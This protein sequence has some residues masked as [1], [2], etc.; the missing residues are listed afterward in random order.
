MIFIVFCFIFKSTVHF[1]NI[2]FMQKDMGKLY[3]YIHFFHRKLELLTGNCSKIGWL[4]S[5]YQPIAST[6]TEQIIAPHVLQYYW[7]NPLKSLTLLFLTFFPE[8]LCLMKSAL[9][10]NGYLNSIQLSDLHQIV[11]WP[12][13]RKSK[14]QFT[15]GCG[16]LC[17]TLPIYSSCNLLLHS[18]VQL[19]QQQK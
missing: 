17:S 15:F 5:C 9:A 4:C 1:H 7:Q 19:P 13:V 3:A 2:Y 14:L 16:L 12:D 8:I 6:P 11:R 18:Q 10:Q